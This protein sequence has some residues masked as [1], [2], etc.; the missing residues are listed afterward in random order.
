[1]AGTATQDRPLEDLL[2]EAIGSAKDGKVSLGGLLGALGN[3]SFGPM[4]ALLAVIAIVPP[5]SGIPGV[6]ATIGVVIALLAVQIVFGRTHPWLPKFLKKLGFKTDKVE[7]MRDKGRNFFERID[8]LIGPRLGWAAGNA[9]RRLA[10]LCCVLLALSM[11]QLDIVPFVA[12]APAGAI[13][14]FG[15]GLMARDGLLMLI[16]FAGTAATAYLMVTQ[17][18]L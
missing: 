9:A 1:M 7:T 2:E 5:L 13:L 12:A 3:R 18:P 10:A 8:A 4:I 6:P 16:G 14:M 17:L 11:V 15:L